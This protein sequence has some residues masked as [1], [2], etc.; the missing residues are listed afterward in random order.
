MANLTYA[1]LEGLWIQAGGPRSLAPLMAAIA[2]AESSGN[3]TAL[4]ATDNYGRQSSFG[5]W[6]I[7]NGTHAPPASNW[8]NP[9]ENA[10]LAVGKYRSQGLG[11]WGTY[12]SGAYKQYL[13]GNV[14]P[15]AGGITLTSAAG[16]NTGP[17]GGGNKA[18]LWL[19]ILENPADPLAAPIQW[20][21]GTATGIADIGTALQ[22]IGNHVAQV[23]ADT[24]WLLNPVN[25]VRITSFG[26]GLIFVIAGLTLFAKA[27]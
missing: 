27:A 19:Q 16:G 5:L 18:G 24:A 17:S 21:T 25:W 8:A 4:N 7:S 23:I 6:H 26:F 10:K 11:A 22:A 13:Q 12:D 9:L 14:P 20:I 3:P 2:M 15:S 1:Q